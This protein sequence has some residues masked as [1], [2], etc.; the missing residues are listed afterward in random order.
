MQINRGVFI[1]NEKDFERLVKSSKQA[2][3]IKRALRSSKFQQEVERWQLIE[4]AHLYA[5]IYTEDEELQALTD[6]ALV[7]WPE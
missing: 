6:A 1:M 3:A 5:E 4:S 2:G 7:D